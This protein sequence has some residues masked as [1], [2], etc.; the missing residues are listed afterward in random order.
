MLLEIPF[1]DKKVHVWDEPYPDTLFPSF[2]ENTPYFPKA[3]RPVAW[4]KALVL[5]N[6]LLQHEIAHLYF[7]QMLY[8]LP[9]T[10]V[11]PLTEAF[12]EPGD[13]EDGLALFQTCFFVSGSPYGKYAVQAQGL[14]PMGMRVFDEVL[15]K[16]DFYSA[17]YTKPATE[18]TVETKCYIV[19]PLLH[20]AVVTKRW[21]GTLDRLLD[22]CYF[23]KCGT[24]NVSALRTDELEREIASYLCTKFDA[25][26]L[27]V[28]DIEDGAGK[29]IYVKYLNWF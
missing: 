21:K 8:N 14:S 29:K 27:N 7:Y 9:M 26:Y 15:S 25:V 17:L 1:E 5:K 4:Y 11:F 13:M 16:D 18:D 19:T 6:V 24:I 3:E 20:D 22:H 28:Y 2:R 10:S 12:S 23:K